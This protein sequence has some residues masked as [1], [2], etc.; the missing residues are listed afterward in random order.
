ME[1]CGPAAIPLVRKLERS[2]GW[3]P[4]APLTEARLQELAAPP[5]PR[6]RTSAGKGTVALAVPRIRIGWQLSSQPTYCRQSQVDCRGSVAPLLQRDS[7]PSHDGL[8][9]SQARL[10]AVPINELA[11]RVIVGTLRTG[12]GQA[13]EDGRL[14]LFKIWELQDHLGSPLPLRFCI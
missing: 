2:N 11:N 7:I 8:V 1:I 3:R 10:R 6:F 13:V 4:R 14:G 12:R 9:E 5:V